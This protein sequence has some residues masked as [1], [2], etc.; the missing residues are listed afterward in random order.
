MM[1]I[2]M[3]LFSTLLGI[4]INLNCQFNPILLSCYMICFGI[5]LINFVIT[6]IIPYAI[7]IVYKEI[8]INFLNVF[9]IALGVSYGIKK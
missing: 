2:I 6:I 9:G 4:A 5:F 7:K 3:I 8:D 1:I